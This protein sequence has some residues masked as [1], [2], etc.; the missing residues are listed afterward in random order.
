MMDEVERVARA[1]NDAWP[2]LRE[3]DYEELLI[4]WAEVAKTAI[5]ALRAEPDPRDAV[6]E[7]AILVD[8]DRKER[9]LPGEHIRYINPPEEG[10]GHWSPHAMMISCEQLA[11]LRDALAAL[12]RAREPKG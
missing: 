8:E 1:L 4:F 10:M 11:K 3:N 6:V 9:A 12:D 7:A 2:E 5:D